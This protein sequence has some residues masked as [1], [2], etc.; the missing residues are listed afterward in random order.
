MDIIHNKHQ[1][2][3]AMIGII[4][5]D[6]SMPS[7][8]MLYIRHGGK[9]LSYVDEKVEL[10]SKY[11][12]PK[13]IRTSRDRL[14]YT[15]RYA[16]FNSD[17]LKNLYHKIYIN[18]KKTITTHILNRFDE[19]TLS[20]MYMDDGCLSLRKDKN[21]EGVYK[22]REIHLNIQSFSF[23]E[24][25]MLRHLLRKKFDLDFHITTDKQ[26]PRLWCNTENTI[27]F[28]TIVAPIVRQFPTLAYKLDLKYK[29]GKYDFLH[30]KLSKL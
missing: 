17:K 22:S 19:I 7:E 25:E 24:A 10:I 13:S 23:H 3:S 26:K 9:Q 6:G 20:I 5:F 12:L 28:L 21:H 11:L 4:L 8:K 18:G 30:D 27:K 2:N 15:Y 29:T 16:Y 1:F 14:G